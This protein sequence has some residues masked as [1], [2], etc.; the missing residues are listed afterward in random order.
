LQAGIVAGMTQYGKTLSRRVGPAI[1][2]QD[3]I[4]AVTA[5]RERDRDHDRPRL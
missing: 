5:K 4:H 3:S 2:A 1:D